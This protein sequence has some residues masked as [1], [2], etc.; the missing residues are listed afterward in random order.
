MAPAKA[1]SDGDGARKPKTMTQK[2]SC[3]NLSMKER[4]RKLNEKLRAQ[5]IDFKMQ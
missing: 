1:L 5:V 3:Y 2:E 4:Q